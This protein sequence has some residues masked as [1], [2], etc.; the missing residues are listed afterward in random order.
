MKTTLLAALALLLGLSQVSL[1]QS[2]RLGTPSYGGSGCPAGTASVSVS[3]DGSTITILFD[4]FT[5]ESG[6]HSGKQ[7]DRKSCN[8]SIPVEVPQ[9]YS[10]AIFQ[11]DYRGFNSLPW[12]ARS[13]FEAEYFWA[14]SR[15]RRVS[16]SFFGPLNDNFFIRDELLARTLV[17][18]P[19]GKSVNLRAN[20]AIMNQTNNFMEQT[21][22]AVDSAD[23]SSELVYHLQWRRCY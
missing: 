4:Q 12:G 22:T 19:C 5:A 18:T 10:V 23:I 17:W 3:P 13:Q 20:V 21:L 11:V 14:G 7:V 8:L 2:I 9:G 6:G 1:A 16:R 15:G